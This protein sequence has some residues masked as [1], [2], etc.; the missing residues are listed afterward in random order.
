MRNA[1]IEE[2]KSKK[3]PTKSKTRKMSDLGK[4]QGILVDCKFESIW[5]ELGK[6]KIKKKKR[7]QNKNP[8]QEQI[9]VETNQIKGG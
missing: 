3:K 4:Y 5:K 6:A 7:N 1:N 2:K 8:Q 9:P